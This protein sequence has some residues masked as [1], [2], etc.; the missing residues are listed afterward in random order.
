[1]RKK[2]AEVLGLSR[3]SLLTSQQR[4]RAEWDSGVARKEEP[5]EVGDKV[6]C[7]DGSGVIESLSADGSEVKIKLDTGRI[8]TFASKGPIL[9]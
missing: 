4:V 7:V 2:V 6:A 3:S 5:L 1:M 8:A 9:M